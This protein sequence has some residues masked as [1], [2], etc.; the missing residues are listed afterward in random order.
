MPPSIQPHLYDSKASTN[1]Y[2]WM[3]LWYN[4]EKGDKTNP[5]AERQTG[6]HTRLYLSEHETY[7]EKEK[8]IDR[9]DEPRRVVDKI[10]SRKKLERRA[11][12]FPVSVRLFSLSHTLCENVIKGQ[13]KPNLWNGICRQPCGVVCQNVFFKSKAANNV[14]VW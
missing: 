13:P 6:T 11:F 2:V 5:E 4:T 14:T 7:T 3:G 1:R 12:L 10:Q 9:R 8:A